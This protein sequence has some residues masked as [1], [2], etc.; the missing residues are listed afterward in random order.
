MRKPFLRTELQLIEVKGNRNSFFKHSKF[1]EEGKASPYK[2]EAKGSKWY[3]KEEILM[4]S[5]CKLLIRNYSG[6]RACD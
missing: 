4:P 5:S 6:N 3:E 1:K 2:W